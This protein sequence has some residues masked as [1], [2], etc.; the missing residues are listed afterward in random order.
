MIINN[1]KRLGSLLSPWSHLQGNK[2]AIREKV[3]ML[4]DIANRCPKMPPQVTRKDVLCK[5]YKEGI[6]RYEKR[7]GFFHPPHCEAF[8]ENKNERPNGCFKGD[9]K[10]FHPN[11]CYN[12]ERQGDCQREKCRFYH[13]PNGFYRGKKWTEEK[14]QE[15]RAKHEAAGR[16]IEEKANWNLKGA[17]PKDNNQHACPQTEHRPFSPQRGT[18]NQRIVEYK[19]SYASKTKAGMRGENE[20]EKDFLLREMTEVLQRVHSLWGSRQN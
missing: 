4:I 6:C 2:I 3:A 13:R 12:V 15:S 16:H 8:I 1:N 11:L 20:I 14:I 10:L 9:C 5:F 7:C 19:S 18:L 17:R